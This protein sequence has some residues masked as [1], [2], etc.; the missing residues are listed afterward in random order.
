VERR[1]HARALQAEYFE[2]IR[3]S[4]QTRNWD[5]CKEALL[6][7]RGD[8]IRRNFRLIV[9]VFPVLWELDGAYPLEDVHK[10]V[11]TA[12]HDLGL[13]Y[14]DLLDVYRGRDAE[15]LWVH[16]T[17]QHPNEIAHRLAAE[18]IAQLL[19]PARK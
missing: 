12:F 4:F 17:D 11:D 7:L 10:L 13:E 18:R 2:S 16:P 9:V 14:I 6:N 8:S 1:R 15:T 5:V 19:Q 3:R